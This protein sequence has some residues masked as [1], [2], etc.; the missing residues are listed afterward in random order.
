MNNVR[1]QIILTGDHAPIIVRMAADG[2]VL[3]AGC[4]LRISQCI[5]ATCAAR[6]GRLYECSAE[7]TIYS[8]ARVW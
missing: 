7:G 2:A 8:V 5:S 3:M 1:S 4:P 6:D